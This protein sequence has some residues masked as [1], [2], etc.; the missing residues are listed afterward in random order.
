MPMDRSKYPSNWDEIRAQVNLRSGGMCEGSP[1]YRECR[2]KNGEPHPVTGSRVVLTTAH[3]NHDT[4]D[5]S[6]SNLSALCQRCH[7]TH[8][9][10]HHAETARRTREARIGQPRLALEEG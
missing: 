4:S 5:N 3:L 2:A 1:A 10:A 6:M 9:A 7:L 8:D